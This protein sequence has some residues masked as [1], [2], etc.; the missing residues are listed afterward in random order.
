MT[1][2][3]RV[4]A[5]IRR[6]DVDYVP[7]SPFFNPLSERQ[8]TGHSWQF[9]WKESIKERMEY[10]VNELGVDPVVPLYLPCIN[11]GTDVSFKISREDSRLR[12]TWT[13][14]AGQLTAEVWIDEKWPHGDD[15]P[16]YSDF[17]VGHFIKPWLQN[18]QD[19]ACLR[20]LLCP[21]SADTVRTTTAAARGIADRLALATIAK[22]GT[23][24]TGAQHLCGVEPLCLL[25]MDNPELVHTYLELEHAVNLKL[26]EIAADEGCDIIRRNGF[27][28]TAD[29]Y[30]PAF[31]SAF[32]TKR[33]N[34]EVAVAH[35]AGMLSGYT[36]HTGVMP[37]LE[38][39]AALDFDVLM[40][41][42]I[43]FQNVALSAIRDSQHDE[44]SFWVGPSNT[45]HMWSENPDDIRAAVRD[46]FEHFGKKGLLITACPTAHSIMPWENTLAMI[47]EWRKLR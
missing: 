25:T 12:K 11:P 29:L 31:L 16:L 23:G 22:V 44:K 24:L 19:L 37:I 18:E 8:R 10:C 7:C 34:R 35:E 26:I 21:P 3:E 5:A 43:A 17:N 30:S 38:H 1:G 42:D 9:P 47:D 28:E 27:Y 32:L 46:A 36:V 20:H 13:T 6:E 2:K 15:I 33:L 39:L 45:Y 41:I 14:P 4:L 40:Q